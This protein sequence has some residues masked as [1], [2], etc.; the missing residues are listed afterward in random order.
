MHNLQ[1]VKF[2]LHFIWN[3]LHAQFFFTLYSWIDKVPLFYYL[4][5]KQKECSQS[6]NTLNRN[7]KSGLI[8]KMVFR[9]YVWEE[10]SSNPVI[11]QSVLTTNAVG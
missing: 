4:S 3:T 9:T 8:S 5:L 1:I 6:Q 2:V 10:L 11:Y 7:L